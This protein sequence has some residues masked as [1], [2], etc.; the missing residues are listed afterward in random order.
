[1]PPSATFTAST[2]LAAVDSLRK[3][4]SSGPSGLRPSHLHEAAHCPSS[5]CSHEFVEALTVFGQ[6]A[7][8]GNIPPDFIPYFCGATLIASLKKNG[9]RP[10]AIGEVL[11]RLVSKCLIAATL[12][13]AIECLSPLQLGVG[14]PRASQT[15]IH[16]VNIHLSSPSFD[17][18]K[19][20]L[21]VDFSNAFNSIDRSAMFSE[22]RQRLPSLSAW[23]ES[24]YGSA[25]VLQYKDRL[26][27]SCMGVY[28][29]VIPLAL[30]A[31]LLYPS[32]CC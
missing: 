9:V 19:P 2:V 7:S 8:C 3:G 22:I 17:A 12:P 31:L 29:R 32:P 14:I 15:I 21:L 25:P 20:T 18:V 26:L 28:S 6:M 1:M 24:C 4:S 27:S 30:W 23:F 10:I 5:T 11:R 16:A 13:Q